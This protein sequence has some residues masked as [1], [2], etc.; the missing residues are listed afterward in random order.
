MI[1]TGKAKEDF[2]KSTKQGNLVN[3]MADIYL[4]ALIIEWF[5]SV[6]I[7]LCITPIYIHGGLT[8]KSSVDGMELL[9]EDLEFKK[10]RQEATK[11]AIIKSNEIYNGRD[12]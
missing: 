7:N 5:D 8:F 10:T 1:L 12:I 2:L 9:K 6:G 11:Q 4:H 3:V